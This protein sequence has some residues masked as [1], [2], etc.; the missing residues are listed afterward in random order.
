MRF[1]EIGV[2]ASPE[3]LEALTNFLWERGAVGVVEEERPGHPPELRAFYP[4]SASSTELARTLADYQQALRALD[5]PVAGGEPEVRAVLDEP[6]AS[7]WQA[8][9]PPR[10]V[11][12]RLLVT[13][14][15]HESGGDGDVSAPAGARI[16]VVIEP[17][18]AFGTGHHG[19]TEGCLVLL[20]RALGAGVPARV[21]D[22]GAGTGI[23][24][25]AAVALGVP[26]V[27]AV[28]VDP[29]AIRAVEENAGRNGCATRIRAR[30][31]GPEAI[32]P[33]E[34]FGLVLANLLGP[35]HLALREQYRRF[36]PPGASLV[37][38]GMLAG[39]D[40]PVREAFAAGGFA[41]RERVVVDG[42]SSLHLAGP[43]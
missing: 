16:R 27:V 4:E 11:G 42:W 8:S 22:V 19:S 9:F 40:G 20:E 5:L 24:G 18:R 13:P 35:T 28:D 12:Q 41:E 26:A 1:W 37:L 32:A 39:D 7:A 34:R 36:L 25:I 14:P 23:L 29:D 6:W 10:A 2:V 3:T 31:G 38:G 15:W 21:L 33:S 43:I 17:G 30:L